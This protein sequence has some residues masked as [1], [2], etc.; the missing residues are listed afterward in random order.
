MEGG[1]EALFS[2]KPKAAIPC[3]VG[4]ASQDSGQLTIRSLKHSLLQRELYIP[5]I[6]FQTFANHVRAFFHQDIPLHVGL[7]TYQA[8]C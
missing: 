2:L 7:S 4:E 1:E 6:T 5:R 3:R 8:A